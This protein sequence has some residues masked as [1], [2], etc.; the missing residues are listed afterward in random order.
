MLLRGHPQF[1]HPY[2]EPACLHDFFSQMGSKWNEVV[3]M[4]HCTNKSQSGLAI[5]PIKYED[6]EPVSKL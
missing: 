6:S 5:Y 4:V 1:P 3:G 2:L